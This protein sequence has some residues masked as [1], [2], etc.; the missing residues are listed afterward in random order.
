MKRVHTLL[1][2]MPMQRILLLLGGGLCI[3]VAAGYT[4][5]IKPPV[6]ELQRLRSMR[7]LLEASLGAEQESPAER[8]RQ[9]QAEVERLRRTLEGEAP[10][11]SVQEMAALVLQQLDEVSARHQV[12]LLKVRPGRTQRSGEIMEIPF[13]VEVQGRFPD[14]YAWLRSVEQALGS[15]VVK[16]FEIR[17]IDADGLI[18]LSIELVSYRLG[19]A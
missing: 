7:A 16:R 5:L 17:P 18:Q 14:A 8:A 9:L 1:A 4:L 13:D 11:R 3:L 2:G 15:M 12:R 19:P 10:Q 6:G